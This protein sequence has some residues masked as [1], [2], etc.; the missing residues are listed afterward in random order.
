MSGGL[1]PCR[2]R[3]K[4]YPLLT[5]T[6]HF[7]PPPFIL[8]PTSLLPILPHTH[9]D[10]H[11][12]VY[13][14]RHIHTYT[15]T[16]TFIPSFVNSLCVFQIL[17]S[18]SWAGLPAPTVR[19]WEPP[20]PP[21]PDPLHR[22]FGGSSGSLVPGSSTCVSGLQEV[23]KATKPSQVSSGNATGFMRSVHGNLSGN[24]VLYRS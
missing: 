5:F 24:H 9:T 2:Q 16:H 18:C 12:G 11:R 22:T 15:H 6:P 14:H 23:G 19:G 10:I 7:A 1:P 3:A 4:R 8:P 13:I 17:L 20:C 21:P